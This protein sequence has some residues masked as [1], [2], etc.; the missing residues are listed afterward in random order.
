MKKHVLMT[1]ATENRVFAAE[2]PRAFAFR[3]GYA[4]CWAE[5]GRPAHL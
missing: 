4:S 1:G 5:R 2:F 3:P